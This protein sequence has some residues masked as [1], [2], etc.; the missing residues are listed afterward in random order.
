MHEK[1]SND[2][3]LNGQIVHSGPKYERNKAEIKLK[4]ANATRI[5]NGA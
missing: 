5:L 3:R 4:V 2:E 1:R